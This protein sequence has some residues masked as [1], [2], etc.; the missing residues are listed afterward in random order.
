MG[1]PNVQNGNVVVTS[2]CPAH[3]SEPLQMRLT[4]TERGIEALF[5]PFGPPVAKPSVGRSSGLAGAF[6]NLLAVLPLKP[7]HDHPCQRRR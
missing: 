7:D 5:L 6:K 3:G 2:R 1:A 4:V